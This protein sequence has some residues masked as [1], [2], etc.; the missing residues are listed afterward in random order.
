M[1]MQERMVM[2]RRMGREEK[3]AAMMTTLFEGGGKFMCSFC[4]FLITYLCVMELMDINHNETDLSLCLFA[5]SI[6]QPSNYRFRV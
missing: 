6:I 1:Y 3:G 2:L 5:H 4:K